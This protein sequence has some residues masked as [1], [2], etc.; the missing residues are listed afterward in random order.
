MWQLSLVY[1]EADGRPVPVLR[2]SPTKMRKAEALRDKLMR[3][4]GSSEPWI[5]EDISAQ[6]GMAAVAVHYRRPL[7]MSEVAQMGPTREVIDRPG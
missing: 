1:H 3:D 5:S 6:I 7:S 4:I 2:W